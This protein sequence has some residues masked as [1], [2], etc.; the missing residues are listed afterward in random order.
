MSVRGLRKFH[1]NL[2]QKLLEAN[3]CPQTLPIR[4]EMARE[5]HLL[6]ELSDLCRYFRMCHLRGWCAVNCLRPT[7][8]EANRSFA[9]FR[10]VEHR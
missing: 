3:A 7:W 5:V 9:E 6:Q 4:S 10:I 8:I 2:G 1:S